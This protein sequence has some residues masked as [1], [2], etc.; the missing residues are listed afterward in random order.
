MSSP[1]DDLSYQQ[2]SG[3]GSAKANNDKKHKTLADFMAPKETSGGKNGSQS[4][5]GEPKKHPTLADFTANT[6]RQR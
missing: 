4:K 6:N 3:S 5:N 1:S 2:P